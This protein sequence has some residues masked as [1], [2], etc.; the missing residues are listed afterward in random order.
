MLCSFNTRLNPNCL[1]FCCF[2][3]N[4]GEANGS[5]DTNR[6]LSYEPCEVQRGFVVRS[7]WDGQKMCRRCCQ[8][9]KKRVRDWFFHRL[10]FC[11]SRDVLWWSGANACAEPLFITCWSSCQVRKK[12]WL[13]SLLCICVVSF[14]GS[15]GLATLPT[16]HTYLLV[17][18]L[19]PC[20]CRGMTRR[21]L[22]L[23]IFIACCEA[24]RPGFNHEQMAA[25]EAWPFS[26]KTDPCK[27]FGAKLK[28][29]AWASP[30]WLCH[31]CLFI[32]IFLFPKAKHICYMHVQQIQGRTMPMP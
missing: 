29:E 25:A 11:S 14:F 20:N 9:K 31:F 1:K 7:L 26:K 15:S 18:S 17:T 3:Q 27:I 32:C 19:L 28:S 13:P 23:S 10:Y 24:A 2:P 30:R 12:L 5:Y 21:L 8:N 6:R 16:C 4:S 22:C